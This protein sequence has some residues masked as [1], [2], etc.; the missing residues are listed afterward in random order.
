M[1][2]D[3]VVKRPLRFC[4]LSHGRM[5]TDYLVRLEGHHTLRRVYEDWTRK[6]IPLVVRL[7]KGISTIPSKLVLQHGLR[8]M[9]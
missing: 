5:P 9:G 6:E 2:I 3:E 8:G 4:R 1:K 7:E